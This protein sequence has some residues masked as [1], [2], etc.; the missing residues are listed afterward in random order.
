MAGL[1]T[2]DTIERRDDDRAPFAPLPFDDVA[3]LV[4]DLSGPGFAATT[5]AQI[6][7]DGGNERVI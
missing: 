4:C 2:F 3:A 5:G 7:V 1:V 6:P